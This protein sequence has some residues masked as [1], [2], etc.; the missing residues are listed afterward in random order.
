[1]LWSVTSAGV[2]RTLTNPMLR[3]VS[4]R[5]KLV[6]VLCSRPT[7]VSVIPCLLLLG[8]VR[9]KPGLPYMRRT[10]LGTMAMAPL[11]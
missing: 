6:S 5:V 1:M 7:N 2:E 8:S 11:C 4:Y 9:L 3:S 10:A